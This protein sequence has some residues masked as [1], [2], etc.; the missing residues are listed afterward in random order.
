MVDSFRW[1]E[2]QF[3]AIEDCPQSEDLLDQVLKSL[4]ETLDDTYER[5][6]LN[7]PSPA[8]AYAQRLLLLLCCAKRPLTFAEAINGIAVELGPEPK[9]NIRRKLRDAAAVQ[10][11]CP[12][13]VVIEQDWPGKNVRIAH[14][15]VQEYLESNRIRDSKAKDFAIIQE[16]AQAQMARVC[17]TLLL[18]LSKMPV[19]SQEV[20]FQIASY[21]FQYWMAHFR[22][23]NEAS[24][25]QSQAIS[26]LHT[27][28]YTRYF[29]G[30]KRS[31]STNLPAEGIGNG[32]QY[33]SHHGLEK[34]VRKLL[35]GEIDVNATTEFVGTAL[36]TSSDQGFT[37]IVRLLL[38]H[39]ADANKVPR[40]MPRT[41][42]HF[43]S[44]HNHAEVVQLLLGANANANAADEDEWTP[45]HYVSEYGY[46]EIVR[47]LLEAGA[48]TNASNDYG[49]TPLIQASRRGHLQVVQLFIGH[50]AAKCVSQ[51]VAR[52]KHTATQP[53]RQ[54]ITQGPARVVNIDTKYARALLVAAEYGH[55]STLEFLMQ[56]GQDV[57]TVDCHQRSAL[58][59]A[60]E[61]GH[62]DAVE[63]L[64]NHNG[65]DVDPIDCDGRSPLLYAARRG[66]SLIV[67]MLLNKGG[68]DTNLIDCDGRSPL[69]HASREGHT[70]VVE[71]LL[72]KGHC[73][74]NFID[75]DGQSPLS[76]AAKKGHKEIIEMLL[77]EGH[78]DA[79]F[80]DRDGRSALSYSAEKG[81]EGQDAVEVLLKT[82]HCDVNL[83]DQDE[84]GWTP[85]LWAVT[86]GHWRE[87]SIARQLWKTGKVDLSWQS[88]QNLC[89]KH[90]LTALQRERR[91]TV[92]WFLQSGLIHPELLDGEGR[93]LFSRVVA[94]LMK[95]FPRRG[96]INER[97][98][99]WMYETLVYTWN[100]DLDGTNLKGERLQIQAPLG[101]A[102]ERGHLGL[103]FLITEFAQIENKWKIPLANHSPH[104]LSF[105]IPN[106]DFN[107]SFPTFAF[108]NKGSKK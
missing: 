46:T 62:K 44:M 39:G 88:N 99:P 92:N 50:E 61:N 51:H 19:D 91:E 14:F 12:G 101:W 45:L 6:V 10:Q 95:A 54:G 43:A 8:R 78:C 18:E 74:V 105:H 65:C 80:L 25:A 96:M 107:L 76:Y 93:T 86:S 32:L 28:L 90:F 17:M 103:V 31:L 49:D 73:N 57:N 79:N 21:A 69:L 56:H 16:E 35:R 20:D 85:F 4:P 29:I 108:T 97:H 40:Q 84:A 34:C 77:K 104:E 15:S 33:A 106:R 27:A 22:E 100:P 5:M 13:L 87:R 71:V 3:R 53:A 37:Q 70:D 83:A 81:T 94:V 42:L 23:S 89:Q 24:S 98:V 11:L 41:P 1:V 82:G 7:I 48:D 26:V 36:Q 52:S 60:A 63:V 64:L 30:R 68:C 75:R 38:K 72:K 47:L 59:H 67:A 58:S 66:R 55:S 2:C 102:N 9:Y